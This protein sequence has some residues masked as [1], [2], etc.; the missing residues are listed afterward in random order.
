MIDEE[1]TARGFSGALQHLESALKF[2]DECNAPAHIGAHVD[3]ALCL[4]RDHIKSE[5]LKSSAA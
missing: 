2:M 3:L 4:L 1:M 5:A